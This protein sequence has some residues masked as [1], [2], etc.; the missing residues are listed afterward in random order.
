MHNYY[1]HD[2]NSTCE[3]PKIIDNVVYNMKFKNSSTNL[4]HSDAT[5]NITTLQRP[6]YKKLINDVVSV[7]NY[8][9]TKKALNSITKR[10]GE[11]YKLERPKKS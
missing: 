8:G 9:E 1:K 3:N 11:N 10:T 2:F 5:Y 4:K 6:E 7:N